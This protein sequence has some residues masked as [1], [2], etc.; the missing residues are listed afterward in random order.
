MSLPVIAV[1]MAGGSGE[2]FWPLSRQQRP[3][4]LLRLTH[5]QKNMLEEA[6]DRLLPLTSPERIFIASNRLLQPVIQRQITSLPKRNVLGEPLRRN[7]AG[8]LVF[9]AAHALARFGKDAEDLLMA[10]VTADH[11]IGDPDGFLRSVRAALAAA[12]SK[13]ALTTIGI[14]PTRPD[15]GYGYIEVAADAKSELYEGVYV[16]PVVSFR[17]KPDRKTSER[18]L[19]TGRFFWNSGMFFWRISSFIEGLRN[20]MPDMAE[21]VYSIRR[22]L[23]KRWGGAAEIERIFESLPNISIDYALLEKSDNVYVAQGVFPWDDVGAWDALS[24]QSPI[25]MDGTVAIGDPVLIDCRNVT[26]YNEP[27]AEKM[28]VGVIGMKDVIVVTCEDGVLV[29]SKDR[30]QDV[31]KIV[32]ELKA[33]KSPQV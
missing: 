4:Q 16:H 24:R 21:A 33:R 1:I 15:T 26:V 11:R 25:S 29:C 7:T 6:V 23:E 17:E 30:A 32:E 14:P 10:V 9:A 31:R 27:G 28:A 22:A 3:K 5:A 20:A 8:C 19:M 12:Q 2:R 18:Y 13:R